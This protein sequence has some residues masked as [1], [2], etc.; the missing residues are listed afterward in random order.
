[1]KRGLKLL[2]EA[3]SYS[4]KALLRTRL[5]EGLSVAS[6]FQ[7]TYAKRLGGGGAA[8]DLALRERATVISS[9]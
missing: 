8:D 1:M 2:D 7:R 4:I 9:Y 3:L 6:S 5:L